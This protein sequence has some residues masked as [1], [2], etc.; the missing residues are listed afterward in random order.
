MMEVQLTEKMVDGARGFLMGLEL[1]HKNLED[2]RRH[3]DNIGD[4]YECWPEWA[5]TETGHISK[6][7]KAILIFNMMW[8]AQ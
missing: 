2:M 5:K 3:L 7:G 1:G 6:A 8:A 4:T